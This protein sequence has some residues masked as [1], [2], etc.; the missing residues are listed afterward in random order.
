MANFTY[1]KKSV[2]KQMPDFLLKAE[3]TDRLLH[4]L[5]S[6][7]NPSKS[8]LQSLFPDREIHYQ[9]QL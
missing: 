1:D 3:E 7:E 8:I 4:S 6:A 9:F 5:S 2:S